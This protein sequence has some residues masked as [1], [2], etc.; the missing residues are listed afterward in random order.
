MSFGLYILG[1]LLLITG[2]AYGAYMAH[3]PTHWIAVGI[4][5]LLGIGIMTGVSRTRMRDPY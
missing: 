5:A 3:I 2:V 4:I 1:F